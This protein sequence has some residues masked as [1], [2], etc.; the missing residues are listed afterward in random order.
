MR[1]G[2]VLGQNLQVTVADALLS[3]DG[4]SAA[5]MVLAEVRRPAR[6]TRIIGTGY[7]RQR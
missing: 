2:V 7:G 6:P 5:Y 3:V 4:P 1:L